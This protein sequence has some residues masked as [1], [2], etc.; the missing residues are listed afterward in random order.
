MEYKYILYLGSGHQ[1]KNIDGIIEAFEMLKEKYKIPHK[2]ILAGL[3]QEGKWEDIIFMGYVDENK[4]RELLKNADLFVSPSFYEGFGMPVLEAQK[5][6]VPVVASDRGAL[7]EIL[8]NSALLVDPK[9]T[10]EIAEAIY[11]VLNDEYLSKELVRKGYEN[12]QRFSWSKCAE[13]TLKIISN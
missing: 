12:V 5:M 7:L 13:E 8:G 4:K 9:K 10:E 11:K 1:R 3:K 2:L 6:G